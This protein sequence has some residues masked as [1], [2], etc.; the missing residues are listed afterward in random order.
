MRTPQLQATHSKVTAHHLCNAAVLY[1]RQSTSAQ[2]RD[3]QEST[4][5]QY[6]LAHRLEHLGWPSEQIILIDDDLGISG[7]G[8]QQRPGFQRLLTM[9]TEQKVAIVPVFGVAG[10]AAHLNSKDDTNMFQRHFGLQPLKSDVA[11][12]AATTDS[13]IIVDHVDSIFSSTCCVF[14]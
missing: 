9:V 7:I 4:Q 2:L 1:V 3:L 12:N 14:S 8:S 6:Q 13:K 10:Q 11:F 5:R